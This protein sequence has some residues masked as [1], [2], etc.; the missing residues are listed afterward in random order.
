MSLDLNSCAYR[1]DQSPPANELI[2]KLCLLI[3]IIKRVELQTTICKY[4]FLLP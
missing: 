2:F 3:R 4:V 1:L